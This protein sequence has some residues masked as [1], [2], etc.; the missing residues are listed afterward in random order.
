MDTF[1]ILCDNI[2]CTAMSAARRAAAERATNSASAEEIVKA[3]T[4]TG[5]S[6]DVSQY[7]IASLSVYSW[8]ITDIVSSA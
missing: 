4:S 5:I 3:N 6:L 8:L 1:V 7:I 2:S